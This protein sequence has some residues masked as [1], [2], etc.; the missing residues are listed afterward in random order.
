MPSAKLDDEVSKKVEYLGLNLSRPPKALKDFQDLEYKV[1]KFYDESQYKQYRYIKVKDIQIMLTPLN[2]LDELEDKYKKAAPLADYLDSKNEENALKHTTFLNMLKSVQIEKIEEIEKEQEM[3]AKNI[4]FKVK[5]KSNYMWQIYYSKNTD[6]YFMLVPTEDSEYEAFFYL[7]KK[8]IENKKNSTIFVP[9]SGVEYSTDYLKRSE[10]QNIENYI[11]LFTKN[12]PLVYDVYDKDDNLTVQ[13]IGQ[14]CVYEKIQSWYNIKLTNHE[15]AT[16]FYKLLKAMFILQTELPNYFT[17]QTKINEFGGIDFY[18]DDKKIE[19]KNIPEWLNEEYILCNELKEK[20]DELINVNNEKLEK[21]KSESV[22]LEMEYLEKEKQIS[23]FLECKK[24]FFGKVKYFFKFSK[25]KKVKTKEK[26][27]Q[28]I[29]QEDEEE[30]KVDFSAET[31]RV[32]LIKENYTI[33]ELIQNYKELEQKENTLKN[34]VMDINA[35]KL[36]NKNLSKKIE[37]AGI[38]IKE[39]DSHKKSIFEFWK[40]SNKD[41]VEALPEGEEEEINIVKKIERVFDYE[42]D[43]E[44]FGKK[45]DRLIRNK[46]SQDETDAIFI[47]NTE[48]NE[49][50]NKIKNNELLPKDLENNLKQLKKEASEEKTL[51]E[52]EEFDIFGGSQDSTKVSKIK[53]KKHR[54][55]EKDKFKIL[56]ISKNTKQIGYK[57][58]LEQIINKI[59]SGLE[60]VQIEEELPVYKLYEKDEVKENNINVFNINPVDE[61]I[62]NINLKESN[63][64]LYKLVLKNKPNGIPFTNIIFY[65]NQNR[66]LPLGMDLSSRILVDIQL[67]DLES[68]KE[69]SFNY[70]NF[71]DENDEFSKIEIKT[72]NVI[73]CIIDE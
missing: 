24:T 44:E 3:L 62:N 61:I 72:I 31:I 47:T 49:I 21:L 14:T 32:P 71:E 17:F 9:I 51:L 37:N 56:E 29:E 5:F 10:Y 23:T 54:E 13:I 66:T 52:N 57:L 70:I 68:D 19:Y 20:N 6:K 1:P 45:Y 8:K 16:S 15:E 64:L 58:V 41:A 12:W 7:L 2:R 27:K 35:L 30:E 67:N 63:N 42:E 39:I 22:M 25:G 43:L 73:E 40:Y 4:P 65:D 38:F 59:K 34:L 26:I 33:E 48:I 36:K 55:I 11:W 18:K 60:K 46:L 53:N 69:F 28:E 50:L